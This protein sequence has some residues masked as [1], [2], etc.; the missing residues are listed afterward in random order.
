MESTAR[1]A[2]GRPRKEVDAN[3]LKRLLAEGRSL[4]QIAS[5]LG[6]GY[7]TIH[8]AAQALGTARV[9]QNSQK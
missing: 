1:H 6:R 5:E 4:R 7:G 9:V 8:R 3:E 2:G